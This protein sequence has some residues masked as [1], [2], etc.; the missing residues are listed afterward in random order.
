MIN[1]LSYG[2]RIPTLAGVSARGIRS[3]GRA[4]RTVNNQRGTHFINRRLAKLY[5]VLRGVII[6]NLV[7]VLESTGGF[8]FLYLKLVCVVLLIKM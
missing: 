4:G 3:V 2:K 7:I 1:R 5:D 8:L 6:I